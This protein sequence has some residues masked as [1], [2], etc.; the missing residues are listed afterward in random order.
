ME[1]WNV[2]LVFLKLDKNGKKIGPYRVYVRNMKVPG[3]A[4]SRTIGDRIASNI[5]VISSPDFTRVYIN[6]DCKAIIMGSDGLWEY[7]TF[8]SMAKS[9]EP[10]L[11]VDLV[12]DAC[13]MIAKDARRAWIK[14]DN[15][16]DD[17]T[18]LI[19]ILN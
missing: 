2:Q 1:R 6:D 17:I 19:I 5:G 4:I 3:I 18:A 9:I 13:E 10:F 8:D 15:S 11:K 12:E 7:L 14:N 16:I